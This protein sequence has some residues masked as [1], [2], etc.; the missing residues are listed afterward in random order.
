MDKILID[1]DVILDFFFDRKPFSEFSS[2]ISKL[3]ENKKIEGYVTPVIYS[4]LYYLLIQIAKHD[5]V[6]E[7]LKQLLLI[8]D[9]LIMDKEVVNNAL[10]SEFKDFEDSFQN[11]A[12]LKNGR[13][14]IILT[15]NIKDFK[16]SEIGIMTPETYI[17]ALIASR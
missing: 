2:Q 16:K 3:C 10:N 11:F 7:K 9:I 12:A 14:N 1:T 15:R 6:V 5:K 13:I 17:K 8:T 4:N